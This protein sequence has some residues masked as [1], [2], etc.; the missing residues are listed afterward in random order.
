MS[1]SRS[2]V[3]FLVL[4]SVV[5]LGGEASAQKKKAAAVSEAPS[6]VLERAMKL[7][8]S[9]ELYSASIELF[10]V[11]E[12]ES[13]DS[14]ANKQKAEFVMGK[15]LY[16]LTYYAAALTYFDRIVQKG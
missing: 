7:Y 16:K 9:N 4:S 12:G 5:A 3:L 14:E 1:R 2:P 6:P 8:D 10:K 13:G 15:T 11:V